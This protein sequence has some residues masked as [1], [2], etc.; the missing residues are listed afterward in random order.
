MSSGIMGKTSYRM[1]VPKRKENRAGGLEIA[2]KGIK[3]RRQ[4]VG[5]AEKIEQAF[6]V[7]AVAG[8]ILAARGYKANLELK[9]YLNPTL[10]EG[11]PAPAE[12]LNLEE[13]CELVADIAGG[14]KAIAICS[15]FDVDGLT[16]GAQLQHF[17]Q[18][19][20]ISSKVFVPDRFEDGYGLNEKMVRAIAAGGF[21]LLITVDYGTTNAKELTLA[22]ELGIKTIVIDHHHVGSHQPCCDVF[23]NPQQR[24]CGFAQKILSAAGLAWYFIIGLKAKLKPVLAAAATIDTR[25]YLDLAC[26]GTI[27]DM[28]PLKGANRII[29]KRGLELL[30]CTVRPGLIAL[31]NVVGAK[32]DVSCYDVSFGIGPR[33]NAAGRM[34]H[35]EVVIDLLTTADQSL[36]DSVADKLNRLN[37]ERQDTESRVRQAAVQILEEQVGGGDLPSGIVVWEERFHTGVIGIVAQRLVESYYRPAVVLGKD[38]DGVYKGSVRGVKGFN[39]VEALASVGDY[40]LKYGGHEGAGGLSVAESRLEDFAEAFRDEC[41]RRLE[42]VELSPYAE[43]DTEVDLGEV[44]HELVEELKA[45]SPFG[46]G[47]PNPLLLTKKL[48]VIDKREIKSAHLK[49]TL[50]DG[51]RILPALLWRQTNHPDLEKG[52]LVNAVYKPDI[53]TYNGRSDLQATLHAIER[54]GS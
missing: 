46:M 36:A 23:I 10:K 9:N 26:L 42:E 44:T 45:F 15:D 25:A 22:R 53:N 12:L 43:A 30:T 13:A 11:L 7:S 35:G 6:K 29:A 49:V 21:S 4:H 39:V 28:V 50:S 54:H 24:G 3:L 2:H 47:N 33:I 31:K 37:I 52:T 34:V 5:E 51:S 16:A 19:V 27:C 8:R 18:T 40:L 41:R 48:R 38:A 20:G 32:R 14:G 1:V 17:F